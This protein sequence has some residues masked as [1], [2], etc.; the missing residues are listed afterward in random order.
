[1]KEAKNDKYEDF[2]VISC[3]DRCAECFF[4]CE[5]VVEEMNTL[6]ISCRHPKGPGNPEHCIYF[7]NSTRSPKEF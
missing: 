4:R 1:M 3:S 6:N 7:K 5:V 2:D